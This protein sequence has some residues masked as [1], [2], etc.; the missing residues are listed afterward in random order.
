MSN[1]WNEKWDI[2][3]FIGKVPEEIRLD[4]LVE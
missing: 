3:Y 4:I 2:K 1:F